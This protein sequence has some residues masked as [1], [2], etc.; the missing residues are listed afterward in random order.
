MSDFLRPGDEL[1][2]H[3]RWNLKL[4][5]TLKNLDIQLYDIKEVEYMQFLDILR[6]DITIRYW[7]KSARGIVIDRTIGDP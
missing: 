1:A 5:E 7:Q 2:L 3:Q 6:P 4:P